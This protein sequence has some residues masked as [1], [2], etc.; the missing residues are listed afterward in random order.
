MLLAAG[1]LVSAA[2]STFFIRRFGG[3]TG[4]TYGAVNELAEVIG[5]VLASVL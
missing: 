2:A 5:W 3:M 1:L 4:D